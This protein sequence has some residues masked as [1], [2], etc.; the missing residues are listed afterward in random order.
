MNILGLYGAFDWEANKSRN[1]IDHE[2]WVHDSGTTLFINGNHIASISEERLTRIKHEGNFPQKSIKYCLDIGNI[3]KE[4]I[5]YVYVPSMVID[6]FYKQYHDG[7]ITNKLK[8][9][10]PNARIKILSHHLCHAASS[11]FTSPFNSGSFITLDGAGSKIFDAYETSSLFVE[12][13]SIGYFDKEKKIFIFYP[14]I[15]DSNE[16]GN[17]YRKYSYEIYAKKMSLGLKEDNESLRDAV[18]GKIMGLSAYGDYSKYDWKDYKLSKN[19]SIPFI[20]FK[21]FEK[22]HNFFNGVYNFKSPEDMSAILQKN[23]ESALIDYVL[24]LKDNGYLLENVCFAGGSFLNVLGNTA[25]KEKKIFENIHIPPFSNDSGLHFGAACFGLFKHNQEI[26]IP[27]NISLLG[28]EYFDEEIESELINNKIVYKKY[29]NFDSLCEIVSDYLKKNKIVAWFQGK[30]EFGPRALGSR[31]ILMNPSIKNNKDIL[32]KRVK[33]REYW[34]P[35]AGVIIEEDLKKYVNEDFV[36]PYMLYSYTIKEEYLD[37]LSAI[38]HEDKTCRMQTVNDEYNSKLSILLKKFK[39]STNIPCLLNT[40]FNDNG[41]PIVES[42]LD[43]ISSFI[44]MDI[45]LLV[46]GNYLVIKD[47]QI[48]IA[49]KEKFLYK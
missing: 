40:S 35:F 34:R 13:N 19:Y 45:D 9:L 24:A 39:K 22:D 21:S 31:S 12:T 23:F 37:L 26:N 11:V 38:C 18:S 46:I 36:S 25:I 20:T 27:H 3:N 44:K 47:N 43:A 4:D 42:P 32:N 41:E 15:I 17:Y 30:S 16:F 48:N 6:I 2:S 49:K 33:H 29:D 8:N 1:E 10:F 14:G 7:I 5:D 28:K